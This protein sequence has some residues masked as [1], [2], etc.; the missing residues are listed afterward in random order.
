ML[1]KHF[2]RWRDGRCCRERPRRRRPRDANE[3]ARPGREKVG[4]VRG[5]TENVFRKRATLN[6]KGSALRPRCGVG[7]AIGSSI[8][9]RDRR[10]VATGRCDP[11]VESRGKWGYAARR[12]IGDGG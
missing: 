5:Q 4:G 12:Q 8:E 6:S 2:D 7:P 3:V 9:E 10:D 11:S 1:R